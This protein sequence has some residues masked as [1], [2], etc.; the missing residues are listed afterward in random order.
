MSGRRLLSRDESPYTTVLLTHRHTYRL[1][2]NLNPGGWLE[3]QDID[4]PIKCDDGSIPYD[5]ALLRWSRLMM[6]AAGRRG[7]LLDTCGKAGEMMSSAG[8]VD[9]ERRRFVWPI[10][11]WPADEDLKDL[12]DHVCVNFINEHHLEGICL[13]LFTRYLGWTMQEL[14]PFLWNV[15]RD[16]LNTNYHG[17][18]DI[19]VTYGRKP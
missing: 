19:W 6:E 11:H 18:F 17:Y 2:R 13:A 9:V 7:V 8:F 1:R 4:F 12:G 15:R 14:T 10:N 5:S 16:F 3:I